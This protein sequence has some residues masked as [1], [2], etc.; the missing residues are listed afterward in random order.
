M[1]DR[2]SDLLTS[3]LTSCSRFGMGSGTIG[4]SWRVMVLGSVPGARSFLSTERYSEAWA[5]HCC[6]C[7]THRSLYNPPDGLVQPTGRRLT[8]QPTALGLRTQQLECPHAVRHPQEQSAV[9]ESVGRRRKLHV[10]QPGSGRRPPQMQILDQC[11]PPRLHSG[12]ERP[13]DPLVLL[14][15]QCLLPALRQKHLKRTNRCIVNKGLVFSSTYHKS[16]RGGL[17]L[18]ISAVGTGCV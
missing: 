8:A 2:V 17:V 11:R 12:E 5:S 15:G 6:L 14:S 18:L 3:P 9:E 16:T 13:A 1:L 10:N 7:L 4:G